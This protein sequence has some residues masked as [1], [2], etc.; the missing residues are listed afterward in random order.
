MAKFKSG[1]IRVF[2]R[3]I[4]L[5]FFLLLSTSLEELIPER[6]Q[7]VE[8]FKQLAE[9]YGNKFKNRFNADI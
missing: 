9:E 7:V 6:D 3:G 4:T 1:S 2:I 5:N 8:A